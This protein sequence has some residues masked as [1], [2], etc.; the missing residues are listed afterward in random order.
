[1]KDAQKM[2]S[3]LKNFPLQEYVEAIKEAAIG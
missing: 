3:L 2:P 1:M